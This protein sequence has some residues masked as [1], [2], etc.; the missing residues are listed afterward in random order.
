MRLKMPMRGTFRRLSKS[1]RSLGLE[2]LA[3][4]SGGS[5]VDSVTP[6][7]DR[8]TL[9]VLIRPEMKM[10]LRTGVAASRHGNPYND[11]PAHSGVFNLGGSRQ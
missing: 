1:V 10:T 6:L 7:S 3:S 9:L 11:Y 8:N 5:I 4:S 2:R